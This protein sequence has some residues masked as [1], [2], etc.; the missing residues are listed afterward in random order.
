MYRVILK[1][2]IY[3]FNTYSEALKFKRENGGEI[4]Q[5]IGSYGG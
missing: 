3:P 1:Y 4:Y 5:K 2:K